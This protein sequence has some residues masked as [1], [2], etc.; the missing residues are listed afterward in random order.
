MT[1]YPIHIDDNSLKQLVQD[2]PDTRLFLLADEQTHTHCYPHVKDL[3][4]VHEVFII[5][6]GEKY[7]TL[8]TCIDIW[9]RMT[10]LKLDRK[11]LMLNLGGGVIGDMG[12]F[13]AS[14]YKRGIPFIQIPTTLLSQVDASV[15]GK[16]GIDFRGFK[17]HIGVFREPEGV[18]IY[19]GFL[20]TLSDRQLVSGFA[21]VIKHHLIADASQWENLK[22]MNELR[23][24]DIKS[25]IAH[26]VQVK[27]KIVEEDMLESGP[28]K[29]LNFGHTIGHAVETYF[30]NE[31]KDLL[32][33]E[34]VALGMI[35]EAWISKERNMLGEAE[36]EDIAH[37]VS[38]FYPVC[39]VDNSDYEAV[40]DLS[41]QD[42]KNIGDRIMCT[43][44]QGIGN[45]AVNQAID[46]EDIFGG[47]DYYRQFMASHAQV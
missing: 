4:P 26:S 12:G 18:Y 43:L 44:L 13:V 19:P 7:K 42:K 37:F 2:L 27:A 29:A 45:Y 9:G 5:P 40:Y 36:L 46:R 22:K 28:R 14:T 33:G 8:D 20:D 25:L 47:L 35:A 31:G 34:A 17:N 15:G 11:S 23:T 41:R 3:L 24:A 30:L 38:S 21:E 39:T 6:A 1:A 32:H 16:L 10:E